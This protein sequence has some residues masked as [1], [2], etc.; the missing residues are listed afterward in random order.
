MS[1]AS[2]FKYFCSKDGNLFKCEKCGYHYCKYHFEINNE[3]KA[4]G[5]VCK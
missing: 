1:C 3:I 4:G 2:Y 5:H